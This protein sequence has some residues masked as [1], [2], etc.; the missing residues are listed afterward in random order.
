MFAPTIETI[1]AV[2]SW[3]AGYGISED[4]IIL[5]NSS[6][7]IQ[8][9]STVGEAESLLQTKYKELIIAYLINSLLSSEIS[10]STNILKLRNHV[11][12]VTNTV[13][14]SL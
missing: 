13:I 1:D 5:S 10:R 14:Q 3:L 7:R 8:F 9:K 6:N 12:R 11:L 2:K 4:R